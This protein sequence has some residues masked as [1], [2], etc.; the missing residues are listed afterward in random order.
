M[1]TRG[2]EAVLSAAEKPPRELA[3]AIALT[4]Q[5]LICGRQPARCILIRTLPA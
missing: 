4:T 1:M 3:P 5:S 2:E